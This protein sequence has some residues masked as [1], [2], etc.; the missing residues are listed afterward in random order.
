MLGCQ[1]FN[2]IIYKAVVMC[3]VTPCGFLTICESFGETYRM[4]VKGIIKDENKRFLRNVSNHLRHWKA[5][6]QEYKTFSVIATKTP[7]L[8]F[9]SFTFQQKYI[10]KEKDDKNKNQTLNVT[11]KFVAEY[12]EF[13]KIMSAWF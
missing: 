9:T 3:C 6:Q 11:C 5:S 7:Y 2:S 10:V 8:I 4:E 1:G 13:I 12:L